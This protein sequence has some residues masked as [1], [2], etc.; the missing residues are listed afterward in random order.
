MQGFVPE[1]ISVSFSIHLAPVIL[2]ANL[3]L[4]HFKTSVNLGIQKEIVMTMNI[5]VHVFEEMTADFAIPLN[6][7]ETT[8]MSKEIF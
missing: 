4:A 2:S 3:V 8:N 7:Q 5:M 1:G 6:W